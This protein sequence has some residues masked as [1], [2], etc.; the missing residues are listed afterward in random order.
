MAVDDAPVKRL[1]VLAH[2]REALLELLVRPCVARALG[3]ARQLLRQLAVNEQ[4]VV[5]V[6]LDRVSR[7]GL[8]INLLDSA[9]NRAVLD[10]L[11]A[12]RLAD[13]R[14]S[15][16][17][18]VPVQVVLVA[19]RVHERD[20]KRKELAV[21]LQHLVQVLELVG[22][23]RHQRA[24]RRQL[25]VKERV[26]R[27][28]KVRRAVVLAHAQVRVDAAQ[29]VR[30]VGRLV[31]ARRHVVFERRV[32]VERVGERAHRLVDN[33]GARGGALHRVLVLGRQRRLVA[34]RVAVARALHRR[35]APARV[36]V[37]VIECRGACARR[38]V[39]RRA[40]RAALHCAEL[41]RHRHV[42]QAVEAALYARVRTQ[43]ANRARKERRTSKRRSARASASLS[44]APALRASR[45]AALLPSGSL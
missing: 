16:A 25:I 35:L 2:R 33:A 28:A 24:K 45:D 18:H 31:G 37:A 14:R 17:P 13:R 8:P 15:G 20:L 40:E 11:G 5:A 43:A 42:G 29:R 44:R 34:D 23:P 32:L 22:A 27:V 7:V 30:D 3:P 4:H 26:G 6:G 41:A 1:R 39:E 36:G 9:R 21:H 10:K 19:R 12:K 38:R